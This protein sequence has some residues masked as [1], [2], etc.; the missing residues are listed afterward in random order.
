MKNIPSSQCWK[1]QT[2]LWWRL[3]TGQSNRTLQRSTFPVSGGHCCR[4]SCSSKYVVSL[5]M[6]PLL[7]EDTHRILVHWTWA[8]GCVTTLLTW[9]SYT[10]STWRNASHLGEHDSSLRYASNLVTLVIW[11]MWFH[12]PD[13][14][15]MV[16][17]SRQ[18]LASPVWR[19]QRIHYVQLWFYCHVHGTEVEWLVRKWTK[20]SGKVGL[21]RRNHLD[22]M[23]C[24]MKAESAVAV[25]KT[26]ASCYSEKLYRD[27]HTLCIC[28]AQAQFYARTDP[29]RTTAPLSCTQHHATTAVS[30]CWPVLHSVLA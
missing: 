19:F 21:K 29:N 23:L 30:V 20:Q 13:L 16:F 10:S 12:L 3:S 11:H 7:P 1:L 4:C 2:D 27:D 26:V 18:C 6:C 22:K 28:L 25:E 15:P 24:H 9:E 5:A 17:L 14:K 8:L